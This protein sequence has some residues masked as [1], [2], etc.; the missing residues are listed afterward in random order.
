MNVARINQRWI[1]AGLLITAATLAIAPAASA[2]ETWRHFKERTSWGGGPYRG[3]DRVWVHQSSGA[4]PAIA[5]LIGGFI[6]GSAVAHSQPVVVHERLYSDPVCEAPVVVHERVYTPS[7]RYYDPYCDEY[8][9]SLS[10]Y[11]FHARDYRHPSLVRV[12][13]VRSG[14]CL[15]TLRWSDGQWCDDNGYGYR[16]RGD[17]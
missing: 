6:L 12:I 9:D 5:G 14:D 8:F 4:G 15:E 7:V 10:E 2:G 3:G 16:D 11:R 13:D 17:D 1:A